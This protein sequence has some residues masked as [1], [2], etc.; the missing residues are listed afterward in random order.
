M[1]LIYLTLHYC[2]LAL[3][4]TSHD[5]STQYFTLTWA[6][7]LYTLKSLNDIDIDTDIALRQLT[8]HNIHITLD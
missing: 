2:T 7:A 4:L 6:L 3:T 1:T 5:N 8:L